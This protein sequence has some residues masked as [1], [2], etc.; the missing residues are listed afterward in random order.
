MRLCWRTCDE[1]KRR[2]KACVIDDA[3]ELC[4]CPTECRSAMP[5][6]A[7]GDVQSGV[8]LEVGATAAE[9]V[10][11]AVCRPDELGGV[12]GAALG[13]RRPN[14]RGELRLHGP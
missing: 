1:C 6:A 4:V 10:P 14:L 13:A 3:R 9:L 12:G 11:R 5:S 7:F 8:A 2:V